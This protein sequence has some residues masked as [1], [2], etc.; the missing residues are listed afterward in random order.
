MNL[1]T[2][3][4]YDSKCYKCAQPAQQ[5]GIV[6]HSTGSNNTS[7][8]RYVQPSPSDPNYDEL[9]KLI[10]KNTKNNSWN[11]QVDKSAHYFIGKLADGSIA[12]AYILPE[13]YCAWGV[14]KGKLGSYNYNPTA[15]IQFEICEDGL[16]DKT[17]FDKVYKE[18]IELCADICKRYDWSSDVIVCHQEC[19]QQGYGSNHA[20]INHWLTKFDLTMDDFREEVDKLL[21]SVKQ[22][23]RV[24]L[25]D[26]SSK[27]Q[28]GA[29]TNLES[30][31]QS[32]QSAGEGYCVFDSQW[33]IV[34]SYIKPAIINLNK[35]EVTSLPNKTTYT[36]GEKF[37]RN[38]LKVVA[39]YSNGEVNEL[40][41]NYELSGFNSTQAGPCQIKVTFEECVTAFDIT[42]VEPEE[43]DIDEDEEELTN[44][45][46]VLLKQIIEILIK[47][48]GKGEK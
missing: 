36:I 28:K 1:I 25:A 31:K 26:K 14:G 42:I 2:C 5:V 15:H 19:H 34:Y 33:N 29:F 35:I 43:K 44:K 40:A 47:L 39:H 17:Y 12:T 41:G 27:S 20:D 22:V 37:N 21:N 38:G 6:V 8:K 4:H 30:A 3:I 16:K 32:C 24:R 23:Y 45:L 46:G 11:R 9:I 7:L 48:F 18:A 13:E 10:G